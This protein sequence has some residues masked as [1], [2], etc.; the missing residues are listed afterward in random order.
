MS[1]VLRLSLWS[2]VFTALAGPL[3]A[4][5]ITNVTPSFGSSTDPNFIE[6]Y[7]SG[8][9]PGTVKV[10]FNGVPATTAAAVAN[11]NIQATVPAGAPLGTSPI[12]V[13]IGADTPVF[14][15]GDFTVIGAGPYVTDFNP[16]V[17]S[18]G[19]VVTLQGAHFTGVNNVTFNGRSGT[20]GFV[21]SDNSLQ[22]TAPAGVSSGPIVVTSPKGSYTALSN[23]FVPPS[24]TGFSP[25]NGRTGT[26]VLITGTNFLGTTAVR[27]GSIFATNFTVFTNH[28][29]LVKVPS[30]ALTGVLRVD[31]PAG[32]FLTSS[33]FI[34]Q[35]TVFS[36]SPPSGPI[37]AVITI[38]G[39]NLNAGTP[40]VKFNG[41]T[42]TIVSNIGFSQ[43]S[44]VV[45][46]GASSGPIS[47]TTSNGVAVIPIT[48]TSPP[49]LRLSPLI[50]AWR[51]HVSLLPAPI[52]PTPPRSRSMANH[53]RVLP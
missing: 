50:K 49:P 39:A 43:L 34:I 30:N 38:N 31:A 9:S 19:T 20:S 21:Q 36:F 18:A 47:I 45:P 22:I 12:K 7:G 26:N 13:Q 42:A 27:F 23:F 37:G 6:I 10:W 53:L 28:T 2:C 29:I 17:G 5:N 16:P 33:N 24:I 35:P 32:S 41:A 52:L 48:F 46:S 1:L 4:Q 14:S 11:W 8:F 3:Q 25:T 40:V 51:G 15:P 44:A